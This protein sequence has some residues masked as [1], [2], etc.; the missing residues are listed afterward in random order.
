VHTRKRTSRLVASLVLALCLPVAAVSTPSPDGSVT[1]GAETTLVT[2]GASSAA[3]SAAHP[4]SDPLW[5]P[6]REPARISCV[7]SNCS[8]PD[9]SPYHGYWAMDLLGDLGDPI[10]A[11]GAGVLHIGARGTG[12]CHSGPADASGTWVWVD[13]GGGVVSRYN[14]LDSITAEEGQLVTPATLIGTMGHEETMPCAAN[15]LHF[16]VR[17]GGISGERVDPGTLWGCEGTTKKSYPLALGYSSWN[18]LPK[19]KVYSPALTDS[20]LPSS[21]ATTA[22]P[23]PV[24]S[25]RGDGTVR[26]AWSRPAAAATPVDRYT[27]SRE[28]W[29][30]SISAWHS[31][32]YRDVPAGQLA[33]TFRGLDNGRTYRF[34]VVAHDAAGNSAWSRYVKAIP[35]AAPLAPATDRNLAAGTTYVRFGWYGSVPQGTPV[36]SYTVGIRHWTGTAWSAWSFSRTAGAELTYRWDGVKRGTTHQVTARAHSGA[37]SSPWGTYRKLTTLR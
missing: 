28:I 33:T 20:C 37:G 7:K 4:Y 29:G 19:A 17:T 5:F 16:E 26:V 13:H 24:S 34:R 23:S 2:V 11:A 25:G 18:A 35:A 31:M 8:E 21:N 30:P 9:G 1:A 22:A 15:Y 12:G 32:S 6:L 36:T 3:P 14:H 10:H 27:I